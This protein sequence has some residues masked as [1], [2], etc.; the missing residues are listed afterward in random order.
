MIKMILTLFQKLMTIQTN[1]NLNPKNNLQNIMIFNL[2]NNFN[3]GYI[4][5]NQIRIIIRLLIYI[6]FRHIKKGNKEDKLA[7]INFTSSN[8]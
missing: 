7:F 5:I 6:K 3:I 8:H 2:T 1:I 4:I